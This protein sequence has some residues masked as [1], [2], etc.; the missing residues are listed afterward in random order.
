MTT[1]RTS[2]YAWCLVVPR[3]C[4]AVRV[5]AM[6]IHW[7][8]GNGMRTMRNKNTQLFRAAITA[9]L[10]SLYGCNA[11]FASPAP[12]SMPTVEPTY[13][14]PAAWIT[15]TN[16]YHHFSIDLPPEYLVPREDS[17]SPSG[18]LG[19]RILY[20]IGLQDPLT[21]RG[22]CPVVTRTDTNLS[23]G[24]QEAIRIE[25]YIGSIGGNIPQEY[26]S[27][28]IHRNDSYYTF[29]LHALTVSEEVYIQDLSIIYPMKAENVVLFEQIMATLQF[30]E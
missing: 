25:G 30:D 10:I 5:Y 18:Y 9:A 24:R 26:V 12:L 28:V 20:L 17:S 7:M 23:I 6:T 4:L 3:P 22:D 14:S 16:T 2:T 8:T 19:E 29:T 1:Y 13:H 27:Y 11:P 21:C 15:Y